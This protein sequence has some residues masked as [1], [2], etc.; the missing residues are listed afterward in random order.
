MSKSYG[1]MMGEDDVIALLETFVADALTQSEVLVS[2]DEYERALNRIR[3]RFNQC[4]PVKPKRHKGK[5]IKDFWTC[6]NCAFTVPEVGWNYC[7]NCG[8]QIGWN[9][10]R[11]L[12]G[13][14]KEE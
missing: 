5:Y 13:W 7:P 1:T 14:E 4:K 10:T 12:T 11:C 8:F 2:Q 6:G 9:S 3:Y